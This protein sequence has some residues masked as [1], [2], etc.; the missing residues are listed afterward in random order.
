MW[1]WGARRGVLLKCREQTHLKVERRERVR[2]R[3][4][5]E[6]RV[7]GRGMRRNKKKAKG[8][9]AAP[10]PAHTHF[11]HRM[12]RPG[13]R[14][15]VVRGGPPSPR[16]W[17]VPV[18][19]ICFSAPSSGLQAVRIGRERGP[20]ACSHQPPRPITS[21]GCFSPQ[22]AAPPPPPSCSSRRESKALPPVP[23]VL[24]P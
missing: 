20:Q 14:H 8:G 24:P 12:G 7:G 5:A 9:R 11:Y 4:E 18:H 19:Q 15:R 2:R 1:P 13:Q 10:V 22:P 3:G 16:R 17:A 6:L 21:Y 23:L